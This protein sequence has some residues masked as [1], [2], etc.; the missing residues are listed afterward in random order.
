[1]TNEG[2]RYVNVYLVERV[3]GGPEEG[4][5]D[6]DY[7]K[8]ILTSGPWSVDDERFEAARDALETWAEVANSDKAAPWSVFAEPL[9]RIYVERHPAQTFPEETPYYH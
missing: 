7:G 8:P 9:Y 5:W 2:I 4:G 1:M 3:Y 6:Y